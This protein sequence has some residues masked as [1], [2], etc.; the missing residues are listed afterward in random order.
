MPQLSEIK[1]EFIKER[2]KLFAS[3]NAR[4]DAFLFS[5]NYSLLIEDT[6]RKILNG[7][8]ISFTLAS[9]GSFSRREL[10]PFSDI[11]LMIISNSIQKDNDEIKSFITNL[12]DSGIEASHTVREIS[13]IKKYLSSDLHTFT[14]FFE[15]RFIIGDAVLYNA[16]NTE[17]L[18]PLNNKSKRILITSFVEDINRRHQKYGPSQ[19][20]LE[21][22][23]K[24]SAGGLR[25]FQSIEWMMMV[26]SKRL[27]NSQYEQTQA[28]IFIDYLKENN[29]AIPAECKR[30]LESYKYVLTIRHLLHLTSKTK[31][32]RFEFADQIRL[33]A[34]F[35]YSE[36]E[37][38]PFMKNYFNAANVIFRVSHTLIK[39]YKVEYINP[40]PDSL[41]Y[42]LDSDFYIKNR[43]IYLK[44]EEELTLSDIFRVFYYRVRH[45]AGFD[46]HLR[47]KIMEA[48]ENAEENN[49]LQP[50]SSVFFREILK[51][52]RHVGSTLAIMNELGVLGAFLPEFG[53]LNGFMQHGVYHCYTADEHTIMTIKNLEKLA[54]NNTLLGRIYN[55]IKDKE[56]L[57]L[58][59]L[60]HDIAKPI[61]ISGHEIIGAEMA[62]SIMM[63]LGYEED[64]IDK[65]C[66]LVKNHISMEQVAF[67]RNLNDP[68]TLDSFAAKFNTVEELDLLYLITYADLSAVN[69]V[70]WT[71]WKSELL[72]ELYRKCERM[73]QN[74]VSGEELLYSTIYSTPRDITRHSDKITENQVQD[75]IDSLHDDM[76]YVNHFTD[77][78]IA[79]HIEEILKGDSVSVLFKDLDDLTNVT[80]ITKDFPSLLS[81]LCGVLAINDVNIHSANIFTR[82]DG[83]VIDTFL[84]TD[85][86]THKH[87]DSGKYEKIK[88]DFYSVINGF[89]ELH[90]EV[91][92]LKSRWWR[93][94]S[95]LFKRSGQ[96]KINF[97][98]H[99]RYT[100]IDV[101]SPDRLGFLYQITNKMNQL[102]LIIYYAKISTKGDDIVDSFYVLDRNG[103][104]VSSNDFEFINSELTNAINQIL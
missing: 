33:A 99:D 17:L 25:D 79:L 78:E 89:L 44:K 75:H 24:M 34:L 86:R 68:E 5:R 54:N 84:V 3:F 14:Q 15:T 42:D 9:A 100:I 4:S 19:K 74:K 72:S 102:G 69:P 71:S 98:K 38:M 6:I 97:E 10:S 70:V 7:K 66:F 94:E 57:N 93:I 88:E 18:N 41:S 82:K 12:W 47:T 63:R 56:I 48:T 21:P 30:L 26:S 90:Q 51:F 2:D 37:L 95:K 46:D 50:D 55:S 20:M 64:E 28:E 29:L 58:A 35:G 1:K 53:D 67:R 96:I 101:H 16:W 81:K 77:K 31:T 40:V 83:I 45:N 103:H 85:F 59:L 73:I 39:K 104:K 11:D 80:V 32:D 62:S 43:V 61:G 87:I 23:V 91:T 8:T 65:V 92:K 36:S 76:G 13:D 52:S 49:W 27:L 60:L 22:N